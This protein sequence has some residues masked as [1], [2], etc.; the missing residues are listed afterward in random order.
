MTRCLIFSFFGILTLLFA[1]S[2]EDVVPDLY[3]IRVKNGY[4]EEITDVK[5][6][7]FSM[8]K[9]AQ[10]GISGHVVLAKGKYTFSCTTRSALIISATLHIQ[11]A[12]EHI[13]IKLNKKGKV[14][15][16]RFLVKNF[17]Q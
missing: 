11:G 3:S 6:S 14:E 8:G 2:G 4:F 12:N 9:I 7:A 10:G 1:C 13:T 5:L 17:R 16:E 15:L